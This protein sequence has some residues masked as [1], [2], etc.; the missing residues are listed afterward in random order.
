MRT[1]WFYNAHYK[2]YRS[3]G[4]WVNTERSATNVISLA[5]NEYLLDLSRLDLYGGFWTDMPCPDIM[6]ESQ[7]HLQPLPARSNGRFWALNESL[8]ACT[9]GAVYFLRCFLRIKLQ[10]CLIHLT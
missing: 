6:H 7:T 9:D 1:V 5:L 8:S 3:L 10:R 4:R 2:E